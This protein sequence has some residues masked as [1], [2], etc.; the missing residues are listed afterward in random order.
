M[1]DTEKVRPFI[2]ASTKYR[3][4]YINLATHDLL[5]KPPFYE[6][7][8][9]NEKK[10]LI[11]VPVW[12]VKMGCYPISARDLKR[13]RQEL[14]LRGHSFFMALT[15]RFGWQANTTY[16]FFGEYISEYNIIGFQMA[17]PI[18]KEEVSI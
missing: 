7:L 17:N 15:K 5:G 4:L 1:S 8:L 11:I 3:C 16:K 18:I 9:D 10:R 13:R 6:F 12:E 14:V 2:R